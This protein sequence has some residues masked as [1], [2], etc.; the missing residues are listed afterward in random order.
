MIII[1]P[2]KLQKFKKKRNII[3]HHS[4]YKKQN[5]LYIKLFFITSSVICIIS[6]LATYIFLGVPL[7][8]PSRLDLFLGSGP[9]SILQRFNQITP[10]IVV[11]LGT[12]LTLF[13]KKNTIKIW[14]YFSIVAV[15]IF[16]FLSGSKSTFL[17]I[18]FALF[19]YWLWSLKLG[20]SLNDLTILKQLKKHRK[21]I[22]IYQ[23]IC[24]IA[25]FCS[26]LA[27]LSIT[28]GE[29]VNLL[30]S[31]FRSLVNRGDIYMYAYPN[32]V[33]ERIEQVNPFLAIFKGPLGQLGIVD[34]E[35]LPTALGLQLYRYFYDVNIRMGPN[36]RHN[37][38]G[39]L[40]FDY[41]SSIIYS[42]LLG[43]I[44]GFARNK[45]YYL[46]PST[47]ISGLFYTLSA[48]IISGIES[49]VTLVI[50]KL[51]NCL[52][53]VPF[54]ATIAYLLNSPSLIKRPN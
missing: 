15:I 40:Y 30:L 47:I 29:G 23:L 16:S 27:V 13:S 6:H 10:I 46:L 22:K 14:V 54:I 42:F 53:V 45:L 4:N 33:L 8:I 19:Y 11:F 28:R 5:L 7:F 51:L 37:V 25:A 9:L 41:Y 52:V 20:Y 3:T 1:K 44:L 32:E 17:V 2:I 35:N 34:K 12:H 31:L 21:K 36:P 43:V 49:D 26:A 39:L 18:V 38:F 50:A 24:F 48:L